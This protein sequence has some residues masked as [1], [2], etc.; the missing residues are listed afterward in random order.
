[1]VEDSKGRIG[2]FHVRALLGEGG[3]GLVYAAVDPDLN[4]QVAVK[5][6]RRELTADETA[7]RR[8]L[9]EARVSATVSHPNVCHV[10]E[11]GDA[12][13]ELFIVMELLEGESLA[14]RLGRGPMALSEAVPAVLEI[15]AALEALH[16]QNIVHRDLKPSNVFLTPQGVRLL[17]FGLARQAADDSAETQAEVTATGAIVGTPRYMAPEQLLGQPIGAHTDL[18]AVGTIFF[19]LLAGRPAFEGG[20]VVAALQRVFTTEPPS[21]GGSV[22]IEAA[23]RVIQRALAH[24]PTARYAS[25]AAMAADVRALHVHA[26]SPA[27]GPPEI[28]APVRS[29]AILPFLSVGTN[30]ETGEFADGMTED[31]IAQLAKIRALKVIARASVMRFKARAEPLAEIGSRL[32]VRTLLDGSVRRVATRIRVVAQLI[33]A[34]TETTLWSETYDRD[35]TDVFSIQADVARRIAQALEAE[36]SS[37]ELARLGRKP[38]GSPEAYEAYLKGRHCVLMYTSDGIHQGLAFLERATTIDPDYA[39][40]HA[41][42][43]LAHVISGMGYGGGQVTP[44]ASYR[45]ARLSADR[46]IAL[47]SEL[48]IAHGAL[49]FVQLVMDFDWRPAERAFGRALELQPGSD[50]L[51]AAYGLFLSAVERFDEAIAAYRRA[52]ELDPLTAVHASTLASMLLRAGRVDDALE[53][54]SRLVAMHPQFPMAHSTL[55]WAQ[56][57]R[58][59]VDHGLAAL[60]RSVELAPGNTMLLGQLGHAYATTGRTDQARAVLAEMIESR[61]NRYLS[62][63]HLAYVHA[64]LGQL[65]AAMDCLDRALEERAGGIYGVKGSFL[66]TPLASHPRFVALLRKMNLA[67]AATAEGETSI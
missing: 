16:R 47:D 45:L 48:G 67:R 5:V 54:S 27:A 17:D 22:G 13:G 19:E 28:R 65:D 18:F 21:L 53:E 37:G 14:S 52:K 62:P 42:T 50:F 20:S 58:G 11:V 1:V 66:F 56:L 29:I 49:A 55:G 23:D 24:A 26:T 8:F 4:R 30:P 43:A 33:D 59:D 15:L 38:T 57:K 64:G 41:W 36:L 12:G 63:Y 3:M 32:G 40:G 7:R 39:L 2:R 31:V 60:V 61:R 34:P 9:R 51:W 10:Y 6:I 44:I 25:A 46:A 35:L